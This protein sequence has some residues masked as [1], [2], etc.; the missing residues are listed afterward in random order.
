MIVEPAFDVDGKHVAWA[1]GVPF[2]HL[3]QLADALTQAARGIAE[4][5]DIGPPE[6]LI[7]C[8]TRHQ[9]AQ[10]VGATADDVEIEKFAGVFYAHLHGGPIKAPDKSSKRKGQPAAPEHGI[11]EPVFDVDGKHVAWALGVPF[12]HLDRLA[13][14]LTTA[15]RGV[16]E[17]PDTGPPE[18][19][20]VG[21]TRH[22]LAQIVGVPADDVEIEKFAGAF[23]FHLHGGPLK[24]PD[25]SSKHNGRPA[26]S[27]R[28][29]LGNIWGTNGLTYKQ[30][31]RFRGNTKRKKDS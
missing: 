7:M 17:N 19:L 18:L 23:Y 22:Q 12:T 20:M 4:N 5:P 26:A 30:N 9:L 16:A 29:P 31:L 6:L 11:V 8:I 3:D 2:T 10:I 28:A 21:I 15:A 25:K 13:D 24:A 27:Q 1:L 14:A